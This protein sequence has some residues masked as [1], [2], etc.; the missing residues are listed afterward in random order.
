MRF[1]VT[2]GL[3]ALALPAAA[4]VGPSFDCA[5]ASSPTEVLICENTEL[6]R[7]DGRLAQR[8]V[9]ALTTIRAM[10][11]GAA[12][13]EATFQAQQAKWIEERNACTKD[14]DPRSCVETAYLTREGELVARWMLE[15]PDRTVTWT[16][17]ASGA[18]EVVTMFFDTELPSVRFER[19]D[20]TDV[21]ALS[22]TGSGSRYEGSAGRYIWIQGS[23][24]IYRD[25]EPNGNTSSCEIAGQ[26]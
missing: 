15:E 23:E 3:I 21:G 26:N 6:A 22:P 5:K 12:E 13:A 1:S 24:A 16:C 4:Q 7:L 17:G 19:G 20:S 25:P 14:T 10:D 11:T 18:N 8:L 9:S 2:L